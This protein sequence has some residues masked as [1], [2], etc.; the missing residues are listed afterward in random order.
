MLNTNKITDNLRILTL[1]FLISLAL[2]VSILVMGYYQESKFEKI[3]LNN[4]IERYETLSLQAINSSINNLYNVIVNYSH[5]SLD[6]ITV[7]SYEYLLVFKNSKFLY[8]ISKQKKITSNNPLGFTPSCDMSGIIKVNNALYLYGSYK[9][10]NKIL[11]IM[12]PLYSIPILRY[13]V[14]IK[15]KPIIKE[16]KISKHG[17]IYAGLCNKKNEGYI[18]LGD[19]FRKPVGTLIISPKVS[20]IFVAHYKT[21]VRILIFTI[22][23]IIISALFSY[24][25]I[26]KSVLDNINIIINSI[27]HIRYDLTYI[28]PNLKN[29]QFQLLS[30]TLEWLIMKIKENEYM[31]NRMANL[32]PMGI[33]VYK[34]TPIYANKYAINFFGQNIVGKSIINLANEEY[35]KIMFNI[36]EKR[37]KGNN[38]NASY[39]VEMNNPKDKIISISSTT[40]KYKGEPAGLLVFIDITKSERVKKLYK[41]I[42]MVNDVI[43]KATNEKEMLENLCHA[44]TSHKDINVTWVSKKRIEDIV[45]VSG[46]M[47]DIK[48]K[49][50]K[51]KTIKIS[52][53]I[54]TDDTN[55]YSLI[56]LPINTKY[57]KKYFVGIYSNTKDFFDSAI[58]PIVSQIK[59]N[60][61]LAIEHMYAQN[62]KMHMLFYDSLTG[63]KNFN[64][65]KQD[66]YTISSCVLIYINIR[67]FSVMN[68]IYGFEFS[69]EI[70]KHIGF[71]LRRNVKSIDNVYRLQGDKFAILIK[72]EIDK[73]YVEKLIARIKDKLIMLKINSRIIPVHADFGVTIFPGLIKTVEK[74]IESVEV[75]LTNSKETKRVCFYS[76]DIQKEIE[77]NFQL[78]TYIRTAVENNLF[79]FYY[80]PILNLNNKKIDKAEALIRLK[81][82]NGSFINPEKF[83]SIAE[84]V[85]IISDLTTIVIEQVFKEISQLNNINIS[86]NLSSKDIENPKIITLIEEHLEKNRINSKTVSIELT[87]RDIMHNFLST[88]LF[89]EKLRKSNIE[90]EI[91]DFG[92]GYSSFSR[93]V[94]LN[95]DI[96]KIDK[97]LIDLIGINK[98]AEQ[99]ISYTI[100][101]AHSLNAKAL[102]EGIETKKQFNF[103]VKNKCDYIQG[104]YISKPLPFKKFV[105]FVKQNRQYI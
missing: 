38:F 98:K 67:N 34:N 6:N 12:R 25:I 86:I 57:T 65:L 104:Y 47:E 92:V 39:V 40:I 75:A 15:P 27:R 17:N 50:I 79:F 73:R 30:N 29:S 77:E 88:K 11:V 101:L 23:S 89:I 56:I 53:E 78:E 64:S 20:D 24:L 70:I 18:V 97:S 66:I 81:D 51:K 76:N 2:A 105:E 49:I 31:F 58:R 48:Q 32:I 60:L 41:T 28:K 36:K 44:L 62:E 90:I 63:L 94:E 61:E 74:I 43:I 33:I 26:K 22:I 95:F 103:L 87:E 16:C 71:I 100:N 8:Y 99:V 93:I 85:N 35:K 19:I 59:I 69:D 46:N 1:F 10:N 14:K 82:K 72:K 21:I 83:I 3:T 80:Q 37:I 54:Y 4:Y 7:A 52:D 9:K 102:A 84:R 91:D 96:I 13:L 55:D 42:N 45:F 5:D 68:Q